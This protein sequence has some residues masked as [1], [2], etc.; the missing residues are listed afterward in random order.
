MCAN[1]YTGWQITATRYRDQI[2]HLLTTMFT[3]RNDVLPQNRF[4]VDEYLFKIWLGV[5]KIVESLRPV[6]P[7]FNHLEGRFKE[8]TWHEEDR[9]RR[10]LDGVRY[11]LD[12]PDTVSMVAG[13]GRIENVSR[14]E[15][16]QELFTD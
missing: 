5:I 2:R 10:N 3:L 9:I 13:P 7:I 1:L 14:S 4:F 16:S 12:A 11:N 15:P 8:Y 6:T